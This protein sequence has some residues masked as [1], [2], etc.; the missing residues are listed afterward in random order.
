M[1]V[2]LFI[3]GKII[4]IFLKKTTFKVFQNKLKE[5]VG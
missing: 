4:L 3:V 1:I 5:V 2:Y